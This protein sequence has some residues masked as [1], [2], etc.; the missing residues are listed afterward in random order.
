MRDDSPLAGVA[1][2]AAVRRS[3]RRLSGHSGHKSKGKEIRL[4]AIFNI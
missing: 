3:A 2:Y 1:P 4:L